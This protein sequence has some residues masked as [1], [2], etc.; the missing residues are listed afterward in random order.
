LDAVSTAYG[1]DWFEYVGPILDD[2]SREFCIERVGGVY[3][4]REIEL[5]GQGFNTG[6]QFPQGGE[7]PGMNRATNENS[8]FALRGG[9][10]C[11]HN[12]VPVTVDAV[13]ALKMQEA[14]D[15]GWVSL[16]S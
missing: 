2:D 12:F 16:E 9:Y 14:K 1:L 4:R 5:W 10:N 15:K 8:I 13:P 11:N 3:H 6:L 7:W